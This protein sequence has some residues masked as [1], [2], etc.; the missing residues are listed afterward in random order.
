LPAVLYART[1]TVLFPT[2]KGITADHDVVPVAVPELPVDV[3][4]CTEVTPSPAVPLKEIFAAEVDTIVE[5]GEVIEIVGGAVVDPDPDPG[6]V[7]TVPAPPVVPVPVL[8]VVPVPV[9]GG[10]P[11]VGGP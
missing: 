11:A 10:A 9:A 8:P 5:A 1:V 6:F 7:L 3:V 4:H 2:N